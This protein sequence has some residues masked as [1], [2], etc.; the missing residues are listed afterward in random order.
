M[1][2]S[3]KRC[4]KATVLPAA[5]PPSVLRVFLLIPQATHTTSNCKS[6]DTQHPNAN[7]SPMICVASKYQPMA[8]KHYVT[9]TAM[10]PSSTPGRAI[11]VD[12]ARIYPPLPQ[13]RMTQLPARACQRSAGQ[14]CCKQPRSKPIRPSTAARRAEM[15]HVKA[16]LEVPGVV[17]EQPDDLLAFSMR[18]VGAKHG[19]HLHQSLQSARPLHHRRTSARACRTHA[20]MRGGH[21][22]PSALQQQ[23]RGGRREQARTWALASI[24]SRAGR[25][26]LSAG[27]AWC[28]SPCVASSARWQRSGTA[29]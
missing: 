5:R 23:Q 18:H 13:S 27:D 12:D 10:Q 3:H 1:R 11:R 6:C 26:W 21:T 29:R 7:L 8:V 22:Q 20:A 4:Y 14:K 24:C 25:D 17:L 28:S 2:S 9:Y 16:D 15:Q 19:S